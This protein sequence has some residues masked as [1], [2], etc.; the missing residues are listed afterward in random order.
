MI[1]HRRNRIADVVL[2]A[3]FCSLTL[4][5]DFFHTEKTINGGQA[6][7]ACQFLSSSVATQTVPCL[8]IPRTDALDVV[9]AFLVRGYEN[10]VLSDRSPR[11]P[12]QV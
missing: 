2:I 12:P 1:Q 9:E 11:G 6:C 10:L 7:P 5:I 8:F 4:L 3:I